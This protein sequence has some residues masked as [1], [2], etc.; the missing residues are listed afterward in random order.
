MD[1]QSSENLSE[2]NFLI[3]QY[4]VSGAVCYEMLKVGWFL[5]ALITIDV[6][7]GLFYFSPSADKNIQVAMG[8]INSNQLYKYST[9]Y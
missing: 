3:L 2:Q 6:V 1:E 9:G 4:S 7:F 8:L 5:L